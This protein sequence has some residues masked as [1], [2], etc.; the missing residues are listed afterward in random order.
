M[1]TE[2]TKNPAVHEN[3][4]AG[5]VGAFLFSLAGGVIWFLLY[6]VGFYAAISGL[7]GVVLA[8]KGYEIF[9]KKESIKGIVIASV[10][11]CLVLVLAWYLCLGK[12]IYEAYQLWY[13]QGDIDFTLTYPE[14]VRSAP[15][16][17][18]DPEIGPSYLKDLLLGLV[19]ALVGSL[20]TIIKKIKNLKERDRLM[21]SES[22]AQPADAGTEGEL[23]DAIPLRSEQTDEKVREYLRK[24]MFGHEIVFRK[25]GRTTEELVI[26]GR[27]YAEHVLEPHIQFPYEM[28]VWLDGHRFEAGYGASG[29]NYISVDQ[30][31]IAKKFRW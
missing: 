14:S 19:F 3:M 5:I 17:L 7:V 28:H 30:V 27:V 6:L 13:Q 31:V 8:I 16:F 20:G 15:L 26:D 29:G 1:N 24:T 4:V 9:A 11:A 18:K 2:N 10:I 21:N 12:D 22:A 23:Q 25:V